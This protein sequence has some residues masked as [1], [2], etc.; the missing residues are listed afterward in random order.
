M[1]ESSKTMSI[2][3]NGSAEAEP[4]QQ[5]ASATGVPDVTGV[6]DVTRLEGPLTSSFT[7][8]DLVSSGV[9]PRD[10]RR[11]PRMLVASVR[12]AWQAAPREL[13]T[14][15]A[16]QL[17]G[18][19]TIA[20]QL[21]VGAAVL[22]SL[23]GAESV[24]GGAAAAAPGLAA[25]VGISVLQR[26][27]TAAEREQRDILQE[28]V[29]QYAE[30]RVLDVTGR[31]D[32]VA[33]ESPQFFDRLQRAS[34]GAGM[35]TLQIVQGLLALAESAA[36]T[37]GTVMVLFVLQPLL[38][39]LLALA[40]LPLWYVTKRNSQDT[41]E[42]FVGMTPLERQRRYVASL[43][44]ERCPAKEV[45]AFELIGMLR[46]RYDR[47]RAERIAELRKVARTR[48]RRSLLS[49][50]ASGLLIA[51]ALG[52]LGWLYVSGRMDLAAT[53]AAGAALLR[54][55]GAITQGTFATNELYESALFVEDYT[56]FLKLGADAEQQQP[57]GAPTPHVLPGFEELRVDGVTFT[58]PGGHSP[59]LTDV[60]LTINAG[61]IVALVGEN[62]SG[63]TT[64]AKLLAQ[65]YRP[66]T[67][68]ISWD[69]VD[70]ATCDQE[71]LRHS[72]AVIFQDFVQ[73]LLTARENIGLGRHEGLED[74]AAIRAAAHQ[75]DADAFLSRLPKGYETVLGREFF[76]GKDLSVGQWQRVA[77]A[78]A[79]FR[80]AP[81]VILDEPTA[82]LDA[83]A[84]HDLFDR[85]HEL[86]R[87]RAVLL[88]SHRFSSV[89][90]AD[91]I[92]VLH[93][94]RV[95]E[96]GTHEELMAAGGRYAELFSL[97]AAAYLH[98]EGAGL[99][100]PKT[101]ACSKR[102]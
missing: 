54:L 84:E 81:F 52:V 7:I 95:V 13:L 29:S 34:A 28:L 64:L 46:A 2:V 62:G 43:L 3:G 96:Q 50:L 53:A 58:Y 100:A 38:V 82:A 15:S 75:A 22:D 70:T 89:R 90:S 56:S 77:L 16:L 47:L 87:G 86:L 57:V 69:G 60:S 36:M 44:T 49:G 45:R 71:A 42:F 25:M 9:G 93:A 51:A 85:M 41:F 73:Y 11:L 59:A 88:I 19:I 32:L 79:F 68:A 12:L 35:R 55:S 37:A 63:K 102:T 6:S 61:E 8:D 83:R 76:G 14:A 94:G 97:Q 80:D 92:Y 48:L 24:A 78:R 98:P 10:W 23:L 17:F 30:R 33:F 74:V 31:V 40:C 91:R 21:L 26:F 66:D 101:P 99:R 72:I 20:I 67:G 4:S 5:W 39:P 1:D 27:A 18:G 65:L